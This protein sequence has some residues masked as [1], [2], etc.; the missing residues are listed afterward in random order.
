MKI[1]K[2]LRKAGIEYLDIICKIEY[3]SGYPM[4]MKKKR[5][6]ERMK[7]DLK[8]KKI[9]A[10][11][12]WTKNKPAGSYLCYFAISKRYQKKGLSKILMKKAI[13]VSRT[14]KCKK[15]TLKVW[16][17]NY[18]AIGLYNKYGFCVTKYYKKFYPNGDG[19]L[20]M[21]KML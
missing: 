10:Y 11:I 15:I 18:S 7:H 9:H 8:D 6:K 19:K 20:A 5:F 1:K 14:N 3:E 12:L 2:T 13:K 17:K 16:A 4:A 21:E